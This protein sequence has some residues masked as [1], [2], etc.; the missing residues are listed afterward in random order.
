MP[1]SAASL[2]SL[3][4]LRL[5]SHESV[6]KAKGVAK[7]REPNYQPNGNAGSTV[8]GIQRSETILKRRPVDQIGQTVQLMLMVQY[9]RKALAKQVQLRAAFLLFRLHRKSPEIEEEY[10]N[11]LQFIVI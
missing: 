10:C 11:I 6:E 5:Y 3:T 4:R 1:F 2:T 8:F 7:I 9:V